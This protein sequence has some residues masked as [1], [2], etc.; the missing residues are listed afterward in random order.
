MDSSPSPRRRHSGDQPPRRYRGISAGTSNSKRLSSPKPD[1]RPFYENN[2]RN[3]L[4]FDSPYEELPI[5]EDPASWESHYSTE[6]YNS[7][8]A[9]SGTPPL[10][11]GG[12]VARENVS[13]RPSFVEG[14]ENDGKKAE[15][16]E[17]AGL[18]CIVTLPSNNEQSLPYTNLTDSNSVW[19]VGKSYDK[20]IGTTHLQSIYSIKYSIGEMGQEKIT[21]FCPQ[22]PIKDD[23][24]SAVVQA[25][26][27]HVQRSS[28]SV[29]VLEKLVMDCPIINGD[30]RR[31]AIL[32]L[33]AVERSFL[34]EAENG[35]YIEPGSVVR[36][37]GT[38]HMPHDSSNFV[39]TEPVIFIAFPFVEL[40]S[41]RNTHG[42]R[43]RDEYYPRTLLQN[44]YGFDVVTSR[45]KHQVIHKMSAGSQPNDTLY[46][47][48]LW[49]LVIGSDILITL[50]DRPTD[51][52]LGGSIE[53]RTDYFK[54]PLRI[55][56]ID[57]NGSQH[58]MSISSKTPWVDLFRHVIF[59]VH[60]N[61]MNIMDYELVDEADEVITAERWVEIAKATKLSLLKFYLTERKTP[62][63]RSSSVSSRI[64]NRSGIR[65]LLLLDYAHRDRR[66]GSKASTSRHSED[67]YDADS[68][69]GER[70]AVSKRTSTPRPPRHGRPPIN[71]RS[72]SEPAEIKDQRSRIEA[73]IYPKAENK[74]LPTIITLDSS[75]ENYSEPERAITSMRDS[76]DVG[77]NA[78]ESRQN[79]ASPYNTFTPENQ[80]SPS[81][82]YVGE[83]IRYM[84][85]PSKHDDSSM[86]ELR[87]IVSDIEE[88]KETLTHLEDHFSYLGDDGKVKVSE[89]EAPDVLL[90]KDTVSSAEN[91]NIQKGDDELHEHKETPSSQLNRPATAYQKV[92]IE[93]GSESSDEDKTDR[94]TYDDPT[95]ATLQDTTSE[96][97]LDDDDDLMLKS[98]RGHFYPFI[99]PDF[100]NRENTSEKGYSLRDSASFPQ[101][102]SY[103][104]LRSR[105]RSLSS[106]TDH[107]FYSRG[108]TRTRKRRAWKRDSPNLVH[109]SSSRPGVRFHPQI[110][111]SDYHE[112]AEMSPYGSSNATKVEALPV[113]T[114]VPFF[115]W[116][117]SSVASTFSSHDNA[118]QTLIKLLDQIDER[119]SDDPISRYYSKIPELTMDDVLSRQESLHEPVLEN[120][121]GIG[122]GESIQPNSL[123]AQETVD[124]RTANILGLRSPEDQTEVLNKESED[125][126]AEPLE[127]LGTRVDN[128]PTNAEVQRSDT[129][130]TSHNTFNST[131]SSPGRQSNGETKFY[132]T[133]ALGL[134]SHDKTLV[135][136]LVG[137]SQQIVWSFIPNTGGSRIHTLMKRLWGCVDMM[138]LQLLW[139]ES[140]RGHDSECTYIIRNFSNQVK[141]T[142]HKRRKPIS[143]KIH[144]LVCGDCKA[145]KP[146]QSAKDALDH[147]H[148]KHIDCQHGGS[149]RPYDDPCY[150]WLHR[151]WHDGYPMRSSRDG[152]LGI[153]EDFIEEL[154]YISDYVR[155]LHIMTA[156]DS[157]ASDTVSTPPLSGNIT[158]AFQQIVKMFIF[159]SKQLSLV[160]RRRDL[161]SG[162]SLENFP[163]I[164]R[165]DRKIEELLSL[166]MDAN[167]RIIDLL[168]SAKK[169]IF[170]SGIGSH[171]E[172]LE[173]ES[174]RV[175]FLALA[176]MSGIQRPLL[177]PSF[178]GRSY[179]KDTL[180]QL[181]KE[182]TSRLHFQANN[183]PRKRVFLDI[184]GLEEELQALDK[185]VDSQESCLYNVLTVIDP[186]TSRYTTETRLR[187]FRAEVQ[188][189]NVQLHQLIER[190][191]E[192]DNLATRLW[193]LKD[194]VKQTIEIMEEDH[195]K[196]IRVFTVVTLF[197]LPL[198]F[199]S[200]FLG[201][202][203]VDVR[204]SNW[205]QQIFW[206]TGIP[207]T[208]VVLSLAWIYGYKGEEIR[209]WMIHRM[210][211]RGR[212]YWPSTYHHMSS[213]TSLDKR[214]KEWN[215]A[216]VVN[217]NRTDRQDFKTLIRSKVQNVPGWRRSTNEN[218][219]GLNGSDER[220]MM[221][222]RNTEDSLAP[223]RC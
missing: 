171:S 115:F 186:L 173:A 80:Q 59:T 192:I 25:K 169:D 177:Q 85:P 61:L 72:Y 187:E 43:E 93:D 39:V 12:N 158:H 155:E 208:V 68:S 126:N 200:S 91:P 74:S 130:P 213:R 138:C 221:R 110:Q 153:V 84:G 104:G 2:Y 17:D 14:I 21:L 113:Q 204:D 6:S 159:R 87:A 133:Q 145:A 125:N 107:S 28:R 58:S 42:S 95:H 157:S 212:Q 70:R 73:E 71:T 108:R 146:Y 209:D 96:L 106:S 116:K 60:G 185:L 188:Y 179:A 191:R 160:N 211:D 41:S 120:D 167:E 19:K 67:R 81:S 27:L 51:D 168:E 119:I 132:Q 193:I 105:S 156:R 190:R 90:L 38:R 175:Q 205:N 196:A 100:D 99:S 219:K 182:Y 210:Q 176:F 214:W 37:T 203:T 78:R 134:I 202:N 3:K 10:P 5:P 218:F 139:E 150:V 82:G 29:K 140:Q 13:S 131:N 147:L 89:E 172:I 154:S 94:H 181:Y 137:M 86:H 143:G 118:E 40:A 24:D 34:R 92:Q 44:L 162:S 199:V 195:G 69:S 77:N 32:L 4:N 65:R 7:R 127:A 79:D 11:S 45:G 54:Q 64:S 102:D 121:L 198:S 201:M 178:M 152:L 109:D 63:S 62:A 144:Y 128:D 166:E 174:V 36:F 189:G 141:K 76:Q 23:D 117:Q 101:S 122:Q 215:P 103:K 57:T 52:L 53:K 184:H 88:K 124:L 33:E 48:Q 50:S 161:I 55:E 22:G 170:L 30:I 112:N 165:I 151:I 47:N 207:M 180:L 1:F 222:R 197:F 183:R 142:E 129:K 194:Q 97:N 75:D 163:L 18:S 66:H 83:D 26:W 31:V 49:C 111:Y 148:E 46:V 15:E 149:E 123:S 223:M 135:K 16:V 98:Q 164:Q 35:A 8:N 216:T 56:V 136:Q 220:F 206:I 114:A 217:Q 20:K 9:S